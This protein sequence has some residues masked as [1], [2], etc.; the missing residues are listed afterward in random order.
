[1]N[2]QHA[3]GGAA[4]ACRVTGPGIRVARRFGC[5]CGARRGPSG[6]RR[7]RGREKIVPVGVAAPL[8]APGRA[9]WREQIDKAACEQDA[10]RRGARGCGGCGKAGWRAGVGGASSTECSR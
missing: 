7:R 9:G 3:G 10:M 2:G 1:M 8:E 4:Q 6:G 5:G